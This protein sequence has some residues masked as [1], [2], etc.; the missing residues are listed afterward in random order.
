MHT[1]YCPC[2]AAA[3]ADS[4]PLRKCANSCPCSRPPPC[5][6]LCSEVRNAL[7][8][9]SAAPA[10][11]AL[12]QR[13]SSGGSLLL[14][15]GEDSQLR[16]WDTSE[17]LLSALGSAH[18]PRAF[19]AALCRGSGPDSQELLLMAG[20]DGALY[21]WHL[22]A[23]TP[24]ARLTGHTQVRR[25]ARCHRAQRAARLPRP[26]DAGV[27]AN[28]F[29]AELKAAAMLIRFTPCPTACPAR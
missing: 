7:V 26:A 11:A 8:V 24:R 21:Q 19:G 17:G 28:G 20:E 27:G 23:L 14:S 3:G 9:A 4:L 6:S 25:S 22:P 18:V 15:V 12:A 29:F 16:W 10:A 5:P 1:L 13:G 2:P